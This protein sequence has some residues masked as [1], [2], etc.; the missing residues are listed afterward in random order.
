MHCTVARRIRGSP[1][2]LKHIHLPS[3]G[4][5]VLYRS[6]FAHSICTVLRVPRPGMIH[7]RPFVAFR[8]NGRFIAK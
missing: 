5:R 2:A 3:R 7:M 4:C 8:A 6:F 1:E